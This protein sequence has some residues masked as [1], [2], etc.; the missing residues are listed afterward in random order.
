MT[1]EAFKALFDQHFDSIRNYLYY[2]SSNAELATDLTQDSF[3]KVWEKQFEGTESQLKSLLYK[4]A[5][6]LFISHIRKLKSAQK[7]TEQINLCFETNNTEEALAHK[8]LQ[9]R[10]EQI[11]SDLPEKQRTTFLMSRME[12]LSYA[13][14]A[15][16]LTVSVKTVEHRISK[17]LFTL[18]KLIRN[19]A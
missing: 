5:N 10:I 17:T 3:M 11:L 9:E 12:G 13:E 18:R 1:K 4:I 19:N 8:E 14:I 6:D 15:E 7:Y 16:R 2:R